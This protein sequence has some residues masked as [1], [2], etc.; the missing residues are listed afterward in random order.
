MLLSPLRP[1][2]QATDTL[3]TYPSPVKK[4]HWAKINTNSSTNRPRRL[5][6]CGVRYILRCEALGCRR[7]W[8]GCVNASEARQMKNLHAACLQS[9]ILRRGFFEL[10]SEVLGQCDWNWSLKCTPTLWM[11]KQ[12]LNQ[13]CEKYLHK[14]LH[15]FFPVIP[16]GTSTCLS[17]ESWY[18]RQCLG[19]AMIV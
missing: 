18:L 10:P 8:L 2:L 19:Q 9:G 17:F 5:L 4:D 6:A 1:L 11:E 13:K 7:S 12:M 3:P 15:I 14:H 16:Q